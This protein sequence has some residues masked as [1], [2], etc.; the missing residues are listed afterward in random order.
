M[1]FR[2]ILVGTLAYL[3]GGQLKTYIADRGQQIRADLVNAEETKKTATAQIAQ[4][5]QKMKALPAELDALRAQGAKEIAAEEA[6]INAA[7]AAERERLLDQAKR[8]I[9]M[10]A[11]IA[12]RDLVAHAGE[13]AVGLAADRIKRSITDADQQRLVDQ[14][15]GQLKS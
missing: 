14:Y 1:L 13:L 12:E 7:A 8:E 6:R 2:S 5:E 9:D 3:F 15:V 10:Q 11:R 4:I